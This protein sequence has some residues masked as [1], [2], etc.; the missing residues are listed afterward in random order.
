MHTATNHLLKIYGVELQKKKSIYLADIEEAIRECQDE[1][2]NIIF[3]IRAENNKI[4]NVL[5]E[6]CGDITVYV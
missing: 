1:S 2:Y 4:W 3:A 6:K 5:K